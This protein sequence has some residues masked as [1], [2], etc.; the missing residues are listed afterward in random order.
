MDKQ[1]WYVYMVECSDGSFYTGVT[2]DV[3]R[4]LS[5]HL[6][7]GNRAARYTRSHAVVGLAMLWHAQDRHGALSLEWHIHHSSR[8]TKE[9]LVRHP[10]GA[11]SLVPG[12]LGE[13]RFNTVPSNWRLAYWRRANALALSKNGKDA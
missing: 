12:G 3:V 7:Q 4:R 6:S 8:R 5:E 2:S 9:E 11:D 1:R 13:R 10:A